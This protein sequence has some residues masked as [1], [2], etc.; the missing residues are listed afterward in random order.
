M[1]EEI[2]LILWLGVF[3]GFGRDPLGVYKGCGS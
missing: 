1:K 2:T 3:L